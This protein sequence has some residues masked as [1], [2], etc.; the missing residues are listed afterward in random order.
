MKS[1]DVMVSKVVVRSR[2]GLY[3]VSR[4]AQDL[5]I[6]TPVCDGGAAITFVLGWAH[7]VAVSSG[8]K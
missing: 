4:E 2:R 6:L 3:W 8:L 1:L 5:L 7:N